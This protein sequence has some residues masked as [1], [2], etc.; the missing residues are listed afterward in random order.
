MSHAASRLPG[1]SLNHGLLNA[2]CLPP[3][4]RFSEP[5]AAEKFARLRDAMGLPAGADVARAIA[6]LNERIGIPNSLAPLGVTGATIP[7]LVSYSMIDLCHR[8]NVRPVQ[9]QV[10]EQMFGELIAA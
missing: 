9:A 7:E 8:T 10:Y 2:I 1:L 3:V 5:A 4:L 6:E